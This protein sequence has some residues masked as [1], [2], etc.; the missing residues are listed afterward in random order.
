M[1]AVPNSLDLSS[2]DTTS[3]LTAFVNARDSHPLAS[4]ADD[5]PFATQPGQYVNGVPVT[6]G[7]DPHQV[8]NNLFNNVSDALKQGFAGPPPGPTGDHQ[9]DS[10]QNVSVGSDIQAND[11]APDQ[12]P[13]RCPPRSPCRETIT[14]PRRSSKPTCSPDRITSTAAPASHRSPR[15]R[16]RTSPTWRIMCRS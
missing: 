6:G 9:A 16:S 4:Q 10:I 13:G 1:I 14:R 3:D 8:T 5:A 12:S 2:G 15:I 7:A 11:A